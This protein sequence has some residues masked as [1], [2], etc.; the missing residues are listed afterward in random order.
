MAADATPSSRPDT[1]SSSTEKNT[2][3]NSSTDDAD[4]FSVLAELAIGA[5]IRSDMKRDAKGKEAGG[6]GAQAPSSATNWIDDG[7]AFALQQALNK[8]SMKVPDQLKGI[9]RD[10]ASSW[11]RWMKA[12]P[13]PLIIDLSTDLQ[14]VANNS[15]SDEN[16]N[17]LDTTRQDFLGRLGAKLLLFP[18]GGEL[19]AGLVEPTGA[20]VYGK[21]LYGGVTRYRLFPSSNSVGR[22][23]RRAGE[24]T[25]TMSSVSDNVPSWI[26][27]GGPNRMYEALD[28]GAAAVLELVST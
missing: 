9:E 27:Y 23:P 18:S 13:T 10:E 25:A 6:A 28:M 14:Q 3:G 1:D 19:K 16:L 17:L 24:N 11:L 7:A 8:L 26:M 5:L 2:S 20:F 15:I 22:P 12:S 21:L 4:A